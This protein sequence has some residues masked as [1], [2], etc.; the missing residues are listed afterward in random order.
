M[1]RRWFGDDRNNKGT[2]MAKKKY[3]VIDLFSGCG[4]ISKG[5]DNTGKVKIIGALD[6]D[7]DACNTYQLNFPNAKVICG[8]INQ[9]TVESTGFKD[10]DIIIG[11][12]PCQGF[13]RLNFWDKDRDNDPRNKLFYQYLRFVEE[14][15]PKALLIENVKNSLVAKGGFVPQAITSILDNLGYNVSYSIVCAADFGVPQMRERAIFVALKKEYGSFDFSSMEKLKAP[16]VTV[17]DAIS[18]IAAI[19][20]YAKSQEPGSTFQLGKPLSDYPKFRSTLI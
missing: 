12:P 20:D 17:Y 11:G 14:L 5:F 8:D 7:Q 19:E 15:K 2:I 13:S 6:F 18:D 9:I 10:I 4:G 3:K 16:Q 1:A